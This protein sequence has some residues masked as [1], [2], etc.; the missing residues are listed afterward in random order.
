LAVID[1]DLRREAL[2]L[3][4]AARI[5]LMMANRAISQAEL[6]LRSGVHRVTINQSLQGGRLISLR[7]LEMLA[8]AMD[9]DV[10]VDIQP[11]TAIN[12]VVI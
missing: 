7:T 4:I 10:V 8:A 5:D 11:R 3:A 6:A 12:S 9:C 1:D 2:A